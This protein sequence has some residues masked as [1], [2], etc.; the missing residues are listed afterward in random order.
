MYLCIQQ[1]IILLALLLRMPGSHWPVLSHTVVNISPAP[2][3]IKNTQCTFSNYE[4]YPFE[5]TIGE[6]VWKQTFH[7]AQQT[8][9]C[10]FPC[11]LRMNPLLC[12]VRHILK[13]TE[14]T[15]KDTY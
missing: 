2:N 12:S 13:L 9:M 7:Y 11:K 15:D 3:P 5:N 8:K 1:H 10:T 14:E 4:F 6:T